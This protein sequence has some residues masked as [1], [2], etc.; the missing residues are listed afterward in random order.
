[1]AAIPVDTL[2]MRG[3]AADVCTERIVSE[4]WVAGCAGAMANALAMSDAC[5]RCQNLNALSLRYLRSANR[6]SQRTASCMFGSVKFAIRQR[7][8][9]QGRRDHHDEAEGARYAVPVL[10]LPHPKPL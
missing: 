4:L 10:R 1:M 5:F 6:R 2:G 3:D 9:D 8:K 7:H